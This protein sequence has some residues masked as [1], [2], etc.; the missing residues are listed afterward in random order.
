MKI[1]SENNIGWAILL[2]IALFP[3]LLWSLMAP[4][5]GRF[6]EFDT[7]MTS[8][9]QITGLAGMA[10]FAFT[11]I[12]SSRLIFLEKIFVGLDKLY[13]VHKIA[14]SVA[15]ILILFHPI[16]LALRYVPFSVESAANFLL[17]GNSPANNLGIASLVLMFLLFASMLFAKMRYQTWK[18]MHKFIGIPFFLAG[19]HSFIVYSDI[20]NNS[21]L[22]YYMLS[23]SALGLAA[24]VYRSVLGAFL[25]KKFDYLVDNVRELSESIVEISMIPLN[26]GIRHVPGQFIFV[27]FQNGGVSSEPHPFSISSAPSER[28]LQISVKSLGDYTSQLKHLRKGA[29]ARIEGPYGKFSFNDCANK[30]QIW[31]AGG[32]GITPLLSMARSLENGFNVDLYYCAKNRDD[33]VFLDELVSIAE[34]KANFRVIN[35]CSDK[36]GR[37]TAEVV[38]KLSGTLSGKDIFLCGPPAMMRALKKDFINLGVDKIR[39]HNEEFQFNEL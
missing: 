2:S 11:M 32:I 36:S 15:F 8:L 31:I 7:T 29:L 22:R 23:L 38:E 33:A 25:V 27:G 14:G 37:I 17:P 10:L 30:N 16:L 39:I 24:Y 3:V 12:L 1:F 35:Y 5:S 19:L 20:T 26:E 6:A 34:N 18:S 9:G 28:V 4:L 21:L 13:R